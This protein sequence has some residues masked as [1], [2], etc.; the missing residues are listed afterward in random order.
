MRSATSPFYGEAAPSG[1]WKWA[2]AGD[3]LGRRRG[4]QSATAGA[5]MG[6]SRRCAEL[7]TS[8]WRS[9]LK[10]GP[11]R[12]TDRCM[13]SSEGEPRAPCASEADRPLDGYADRIRAR[14]RGVAVERG[15]EGVATA[16]D[17]QGG[18]EGVAK[19]IDPAR[20][21]GT[22]TSATAPSTLE[23]WHFS[24]PNS[25]L[26]KLSAAERRLH[27]MRLEALP[28]DLGPAEAQ[29]DAHRPLRRA[30]ASPASVGI[31]TTP[32]TAPPLRRPPRPDLEAP[33]GSLRD[34][35]GN[36]NAGPE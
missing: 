35:S 30:L 16:S 19:Q 3:T 4:A 21:S 13:R 28:R 5:L 9:L 7:R 23:A 26:E 22:W 2:L 27:R 24:D 12:I 15:F 29:S 20:R 18:L 25:C 36:R 17:L 32:D 1:P 33:D 11:G 14:R 10:H 6:E 8:S 34:F 31:G